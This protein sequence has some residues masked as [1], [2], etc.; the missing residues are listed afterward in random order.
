ME[1]P[2]VIIAGVIGMGLV[3]AIVGARR[4]L[5][6]PTPDERPALEQALGQ[7]LAAGNR[8]E[9]VALYRRLTLADERTAE[10]A[11]E[12]KLAQRA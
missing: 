9:A 4:E 3:G 12:R 8:T 6:A 11:I 1:F 2:F 7:V 10:A 5:V